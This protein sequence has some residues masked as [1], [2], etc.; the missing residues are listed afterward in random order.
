MRLYWIRDF[1]NA[2]YRGGYP[3]AMAERRDI[4]DLGDCY[5]AGNVTSGLFVTRLLDDGKAEVQTEEWP[6]SAVSTDEAGE[7]LLR[8]TERGVE[9]A[10]FV[11]D[12]TLVHLTLAGGRLYASVAAGT[13]AAAGAAL[14]PRMLS[15]AGSVVNP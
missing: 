9:R 6:T 8:V 2:A 3:A 11:L 14:P 1:R 15:R 5:G 12:E 13:R 10:L 4:I 7:P